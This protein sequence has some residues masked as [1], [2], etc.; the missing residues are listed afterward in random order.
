[1]RPVA[2]ADRLGRPGIAQRDKAITFGQKQILDLLT[3]S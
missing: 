3:F 2:L 1:M